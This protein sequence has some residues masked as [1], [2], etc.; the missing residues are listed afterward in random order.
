MQELYL[1]WAAVGAIVLVLGLYSSLLKRTILSLPMAALLAGIALGPAL[2]LLNPARWGPSPEKIL[3]EAAR[4]TLAIALMGVALRLPPGFLKRCWKPVSVLVGLGMALMWLSASLIVYLLLDVSPLVALLVGGVIIPT[5][6]VVASSVVS[7][8]VAEDNVS[9]DVRHTLSAESG[10]NDGLAYPFVMLLAVLL[11]QPA[12]SGW[13]Y[14]LTHNLIVDVGGAVLFGALLGIASGHLL[15]KAEA[16]HTVEHDSFLA[17]TVALSLLALGSAKLLDINGILTVFAAG[18]AFDQVVGGSERSAEEN[19]QEAFNQFF[20]LPIF[21]LF[22]LMLPW[23]QWLTLGWAGPALVVA[24][25]LLRRLP[26]LLLLRP[27]ISTL[28]HRLDAAYI[29]WFGPIGVAT[30]L[31]AIHAKTLTG[32]NLVWTVGSL[33]V[34]ASLVVHGVTASP[35][36]FW[37]GRHRKPEQHR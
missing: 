18:V 26:A 14:W 20:T 25:L 34:F 23:Q 29:G 31:Y 21:V 4:V 17:H 13:T 15:R 35:F 24:V 22:G 28:P 27:L 10:S 7:G 11:T 5:D 12:S 6:P 30:L 16:K 9:E 37:Y 2:D 3:E 1:G 36:T 32:E 8:K 33:M 19:V